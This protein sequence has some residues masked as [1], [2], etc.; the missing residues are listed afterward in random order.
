[1]PSFWEDQL[2]ITI[3]PLKIKSGVKKRKGG[4]VSH[5]RASVAH[6]V[7]N[8]SKLGESKQKQG[9]EKGL[10]IQKEQQSLS[11]ER[12]YTLHTGLQTK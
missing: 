5:V 6:D 10:K 1:M 2:M 8:W 7:S 3:I 4:Y 11:P 9:A 12:K